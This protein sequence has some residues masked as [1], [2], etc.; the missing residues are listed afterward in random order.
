MISAC[1]DEATKQPVV[2]V[3]N[4]LT[5]S[6]ALNLTGARF[7][8]GAVKSYTTAASLELTYSTVSNLSKVDIEPKAIVT[9]AG[10]Y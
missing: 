5:T 2:V 3:M 8:S 6:Q 7:A 10:N 1:K 4:I 9:F